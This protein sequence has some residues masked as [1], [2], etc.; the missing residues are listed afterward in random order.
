MGATNIE[1]IE[2]LKTLLVATQKC[3]AL[4]IGEAAPCKMKMVVFVCIT[5]ATLYLTK[6]PKDP[7]ELLDFFSTFFSL[8]EDTLS[9]ILAKLKEIMMATLPAQN[10]KDDDAKS[11]A[12]ESDDPQ[13]NEVIFHL[14]MVFEQFLHDQLCSP[15][16]GPE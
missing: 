3:L 9:Q 8:N 2:G 12:K 7:I 11:D 10:T 4:S 1:A 15:G 6:D 13:H 14:D 16:A 5:I